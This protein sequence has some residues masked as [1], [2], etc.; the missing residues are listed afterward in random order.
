MPGYD[1]RTIGE[2]ARGELFEIRRLGVGKSA[3]EISGAD[4][5]GR[6]F[7]LSDCRSKVVVLIFTANWCG[8][9]RVMYPQLRNLQQRSRTEP[10]AVVGVD[11]DSDKETLRESIRS[12]RITWR[13][14]WDGGTE[15]PTTTAWGVSSFPTIYLLDRSGVIRFK[16]V[17]GDNLEQAVAS[18]LR[19][20]EASAPPTRLP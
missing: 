17:R 18:L 19:E 4:V 9:C 2:V 15:G 12:G 14:W 20:P 10:L 11:T 3:P 16:D 8:P 7:H 1:R 5:D 6:P 13:C